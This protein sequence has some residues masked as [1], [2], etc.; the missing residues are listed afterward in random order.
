MPEHDEVLE[1]ITK[2][3]N[4]AVPEGAPSVTANSDLVND[5]GLDSMKVLEIMEALEDSFDISIPMN[6]MPEVRTVNDLTVQIKKL[7]ESE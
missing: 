1:L 7:T 3:L 2:I 6:I 5:L 4:K